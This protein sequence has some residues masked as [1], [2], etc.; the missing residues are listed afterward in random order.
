MRGCFEIPWRVENPRLA[1]KA[2]AGIR[3]LDLILLRIE[4]SMP[5][6]TQ[7]KLSVADG[8]TGA[9]ARNQPCPSGP[10]A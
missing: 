9:L 7:K 8:R 3:T 4:R 5:S 2:A 1:G 6:R 10:P